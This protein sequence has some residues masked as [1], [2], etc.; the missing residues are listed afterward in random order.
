MPGIPYKLL[1]WIQPHRL[2]PKYLSR[3]P[4]GIQWLEKN[5]DKIFWPEL[6]RNKSP[7]ATYLLEKNPDKIVWSSLS[8][9]DNPSAIRMLERKIQSTPWY[10]GYVDWWEENIL[11]RYYYYESYVRRISWYSLSANPGAIH[12]LEQYPHIIDFEGLCCNPKLNLWAMR[13]L[14]KNLDKIDWSYLSQNPSIFAKQLFE[15]Y[16][17]KICWRYLS[18]NSSDWAIQLLKQNPDK[19]HWWSLSKNTH[20]AIYRIFETKITQNIKHNEADLTLR[21]AR[22]DWFWLSGNPSAWAIQ[23]LEKRIL[24]TKRK[25]EPNSNEFSIIS[26][27]IDNWMLSK[28][29]NAI[30]LLEQ[31]QHRISYLD[32]SQ[33]PN[34]FT[35]D[36]EEMK[37]FKNRLHEDLIQTMFHPTNI[38]KFEGWGFDADE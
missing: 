10:Q 16:P 35:Y 32:F 24:E 25:Y 9:N 11:G 30:H 1:D 29:P 13:V 14:E 38:E 6:C 3:N 23:L 36:Y 12:L 28:N 7:F 17:E 26:N 19:I 15:T 20:P 2:N 37:W 22:I 31:N 4:H 8:E 33:N 5:P 18:S 34:I 21:Y 27:E